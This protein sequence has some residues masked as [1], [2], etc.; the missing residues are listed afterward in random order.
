MTPNV[1]W[2]LIYKSTKGKVDFDKLTKDYE[3]LLL[4]EGFT[5]MLKCSETISSIL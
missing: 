3:K 2:S 4:F 5:W 1:K